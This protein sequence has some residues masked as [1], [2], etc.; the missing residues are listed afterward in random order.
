[1]KFLD[2]FSGIG[3]FHYAMKDA[4]PNSQCVGAIEKDKSAAA[5]YK[6]NHGI[7][8]YED[9]TKI[10]PQDL[11]NFDVLFGGFPCQPFSRNGKVYNFNH[12]L[13]LDD[14]RALL[15]DYLLNIARIKQPNYLLFENVKGIKAVS[16][17]LVFDYVCEQ[18]VN[19][20]YNLSIVEVDSA[21]YKVPQQRQRVFFLGS[22]SPIPSN[23]TYY[24]RTLCVRDIM[25]EM[26]DDRYYIEQLWNNRLVTLQRPDRA[27]HTQVKGTKRLNAFYELLQNATFPQ[28]KTYK[29]TP[30]VI[31][32]G[33]TPSGTARQQDKLYSSLG[34]SP[35]LA[36]FATPCFDD[37][38]GRYR[39]LTPR[40]CSRLQG[41]PE[42]HIL[43]HTNSLGYKQL[44]N[45]VTVTT[46]TEVIKLL[47]G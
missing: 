37:G 15:V 31:V 25:S 22:K 7:E 27:N 3:G 34:I 6:I 36:T 24:E 43:P 8:P 33:E 14:E 45:A 47:I 23:I 35:T 12:D 44:G 16:D 5:N 13:L 42:S 21:D 1:M 18:I 26:V 40:E 28:Q 29:I 2:A 46:A 10:V 39:V 20:G 30:L 38:N 17:G 41:F 9:I 32:Y 4:Y 19:L 11:P